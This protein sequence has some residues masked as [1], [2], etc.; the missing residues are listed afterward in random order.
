MLIHFTIELWY[1]ESIKYLVNVEDKST[2]V[3]KHSLQR[4]YEYKLLLRKCVNMKVKSERM[5]K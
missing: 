4:K 3:L 5:G 2:N 1:I